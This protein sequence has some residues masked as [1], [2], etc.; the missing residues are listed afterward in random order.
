VIPTV[1]LVG[2]VFGFTYG[3]THRVGVVGLGAAVA[4][5]GWWLLLFTVGDVVVTPATVLGAGVLTL[6]NYAAAALAG[7]GLGRL[8]RAR[9]GMTT[10]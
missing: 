4:V 3:V 6:A 9:F 7:W 2:V 10:E 8:L 5:V 1:L